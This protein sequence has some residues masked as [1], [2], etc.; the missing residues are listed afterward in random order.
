V[1]LRE[2]FA[3]VKQELNRAWRERDEARAEVAALRRQLAEKERQNQKLQRQLEQQRAR[4]QKLKDE[5]EQLREEQRASKR[6]A[7]PFRRREREAQPRRPGRKPGH[8]AAHRPMP[9]HI[10]EEIHVPLECCPHCG[11]SVEDV[12]PMAPQV[13]TDLPP[14]IKLVVRRYH[15]QR[16]YCRHCK[17]RVRSRHPEQSSTANGAAGCQVGPR[18]MSLAVDLKYRVGIVYEKVRELFLVAF[19]LSISRAAL[20][21]AAQRIARR[22]EPTY[23][24]MLDLLRSAAVVHADETGWYIARASRQAWLWL[25]AAREP[26]VTLY[27]IRL[28]RG[29]GVVREVMGDWFVGVMQI[30]GWCAYFELDCPKAQCAAH[31]LRRVAK[32]LEAQTRGAARFPLGVKRLL[33]QAIALKAM[34]DELSPEV[35][36][37]CR[38][39]LQGELVALL[40]GQIEEPENRKLAKH[41]RRHDDELLRFL[42]VPAVEATNNFAEREVR[43]AVLARKVS[44]GNRTEA[45]A[46]AQEV[47]ASVA[48]T[49]RRNELLLVDVLPVLLCATERD[50]VLPIFAEVTAEAAASPGEERGRRAERE[51]QE[52]AVGGVRRRRRVRRGRRRA[53][54]EDRACARAP[55]GAADG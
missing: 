27:V 26:R 1:H 13:V 53:G 41:L 14:E 3:P 10:D 39:Q 29:G 33:L 45:G 28:S 16:G 46:H 50:F 43:P 37:A 2:L 35:F 20:A 30:D 49:A 19:G 34:Q 6:Q 18:A 44:A 7:A 51:L 4:N 31:I 5:L 36:A 12:E 25:F 38:E 9:D 42:D 47:L 54:A 32:M 15:N 48:R 21:R 55:P 40:A 52:A 24:V 8:P 22:C 23:E 17:R 11:G